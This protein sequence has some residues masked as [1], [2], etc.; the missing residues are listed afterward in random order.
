MVTL[1]NFDKNDIYILQ[2]LKYGD[3]S[4]NKIEKMIN[5]W[6]TKENDGK[7]FE[8]FAVVSNYAIVGSVSLYHHSESV[9]SCGAE[10]FKDFRRKNFAYF[11]V[12]EMFKIA[13]E[14]GYIMAT[15]QVRT[16]NTASLALCRKLGFESDYYEYINKKGNK[17][18][19]F[20]K[21]LL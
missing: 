15:G 2:N 19:I 12:S 16:D 13:K 6:N 8:M 9:V 17:V 10:I 21:S 11:A 14:K 3:I 20:M 7:Y 1:R 4:H 18:Y 5:D